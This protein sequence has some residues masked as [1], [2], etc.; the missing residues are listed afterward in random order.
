MERRHIIEKGEVKKEKK[1]TE[2]YGRPLMAEKDGKALEA[3]LAVT[4]CTPT[5]E[6]EAEM[7]DDTSQE[8]HPGYNLRWGL[9]LLAACV[10]SPV[11]PQFISTTIM[12]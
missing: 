3:Y 11:V 6:S 9:T 7:L 2:N 8:P 1:R 12:S 10:E 4:L 5:A